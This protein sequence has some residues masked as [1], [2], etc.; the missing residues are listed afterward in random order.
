MISE[1]QMVMK[2]DRKPIYPANLLVLGRQC[3]VVGGGR[4]AIRKASGLAEAG[5]NVTLVASA[6]RKEAAA[7]MGLRYMER[8]FRSGDL[9][10]MWLVFAAT[11]DTALNRRILGLCRRRGILGCAVDAGWPEGDFITPASFL[12]DGMTVAVGSG[13]SACRRSRM[14]RDRLRREPSWLIRPEPVVLATDASLMDD[15]RRG[16]LPVFRKGVEAVGDMLARIQGVHEFVLLA[17]C[18]RVELLALMVPDESTLSL[19]KLAMGL[20]A[21][22]EQE[23]RLLRGREAFLHPALVALGRL[24]RNRGERHVEGQVK[25]AF[26]QAAGRNWAGLGMDLWFRQILPLVRQGRRRS[27]AHPAVGEIEDRV[28]ERIRQQASPARE[29][30]AVILCGT[31][32]LGRKMARRLAADGLLLH[33]LY[34]HRPPRSLPGVNVQPMTELFRLLP[35]A[36]TLV[37]AVRSPQPLLTAASAGILASSPVSLVVDLGMPRNADPNLATA[38]FRGELVDLAGLAPRPP[39]DDN[40]EP[41]F[42]EGDADERYVQFL[43]ALADRHPGE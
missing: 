7:A 8:P 5:A 32:Y 33:W 15:L 35:S 9:A 2:T 23:V 11:D 17:T 38:G 28:L 25:A 27:K 3:L 29:K 26:V 42:S 41:P 39:S 13:G 10:G 12:H 21:V 6:V 31:G 43:S 1:M 19:A 40:M 22:P 30:P 24:S 20:A 36:T 4:V 16:S 37:L 14:L 18:D 34:H